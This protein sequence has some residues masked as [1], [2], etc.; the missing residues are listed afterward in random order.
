MMMLRKPALNR[1]AAPLLLVL[2]ASSTNVLAAE[3]TPSSGLTV[4][5]VPTA[6]RREVGAIDLTR[7]GDHFHV[8][9]TNT[10]PK[11][12]R[13]WREWCSWGY[14]ALS[15]EAQDQAGKAFRIS[16]KQRGWDKN[17]P[18][19][20]ELA[21]GE[22]AVIDVNLDPADW[23]ASPLSSSSWETQLRMR[24][25]YGLRD[26]CLRRSLWARPIRHSAGSERRSCQRNPPELLPWHRCLPVPAGCRLRR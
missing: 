20:M 4:R 26:S 9:L 1:V 2:C 13:I 3:A 24:A 17:Y 8:V 19:W 11:P 16:K 14:F 25:P 7:L 22:P 18:D 15:F 12:I 10:S 5:I 6:K 21:P 23:E